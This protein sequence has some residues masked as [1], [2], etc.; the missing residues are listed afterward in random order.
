[1]SN[2][3]QEIRHRSV[4]SRRLSDRTIVARLADGAPIVL[5]STAATVWHALEDWVTVDEIDRHLEEAFPNVS[6]LERHSA[7]QQILVTLM[8]ENLIEQH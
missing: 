8:E 7:R 2:A 6:V 5:A 3:S 1:M 4:P